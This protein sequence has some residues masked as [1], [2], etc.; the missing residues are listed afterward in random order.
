MFRFAEVEVKEIN[1]SGLLTLQMRERVSLINEGKELYPEMF[2]LFFLKSSEEPVTLLQ[3]E[4]VNYTDVKI[5]IQLTFDSPLLVSTGLQPDHV[6]LHMS[7]F[8]FLPVY[9][10]FRIVA[11]SELVANQS[12]EVTLYADLPMQVVSKGKF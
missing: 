7:R 5:Q 6:K 9:E 3:W 8:L 11:A 2:E 1:E 4:L 12:K 10:P